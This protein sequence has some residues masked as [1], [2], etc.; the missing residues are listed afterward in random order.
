MTVDNPTQ[1][2]Q[3]AEI[4]AMTE[5]ARALQPLEAE[6]RR[7]VL[8]WAA[9]SFG[10]TV[11]LGSGAKNVAGHCDR[12]LGGEGLRDLTDR[13][14]DLA[15]LYTATAPKS[16]PEKAL[17]VGY[18]FQKMGNDADFDSGSV[19]RELNQL[20]YRIGNITSALGSLI[21]RKPQ[22]VIQTRK[23]GSTQQA[24]KRYRLTNEGIKQVERML[25]GGNE[26]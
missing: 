5:I 20:G 8:Q 11:V 1:N 3:M 25:P 16:D 15:E 24:R 17:V 14:T 19:N 12:D 4:D 22:M 23:S 9:D 18:W 26:Q 21:A 7:R 10:A 6:S 13:F 2:S